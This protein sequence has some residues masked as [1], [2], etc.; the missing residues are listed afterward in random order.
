[1]K[2]NIGV[3]NKTIQARLF[4]VGSPRSGTT[5]LQSVLAAHPQIASFP[6]S[7]FLLVTSRTRRGRWMRK[8]GLVSPEMRLRLAQFLDEI[9]R[10][11]C[12]SLFPQRDIRLKSFT[13]AFVKLLDRLTLAQGKNIWLE[14]TPG[15]LYYINDF[16]RYIPEAKFIHL[17][18]NGADVV[19]SLYEV[20]NQYPQ[21]WGRAYDL[22][23]CI[24]TWNQAVKRTEKQLGKPN[25]IGVRYEALIAHPE[26]ILSEL[27][28]GIGVSF[29]PT[30]LSDYR[31][32]AK[33]LILAHETWKEAVTSEIHKPNKRKFLTIFT[34]EEQSYIL[35]RLRRKA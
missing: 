28:H 15:H 12:R 34:P 7:H 13:T 35:E 23:R 4:L 24:R 30:M 2:Q 26:Q 1:M 6:E 18:R 10:P 8:L 17:V 9:G 3:S 27:C 21:D 5:L 14:K 32:R 16:E 11:E 20:T 19:A 31:E 33:H 29:E 22:E 25:H